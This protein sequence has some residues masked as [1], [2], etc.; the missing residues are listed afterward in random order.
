MRN[1]IAKGFVGFRLNHIHYYYTPK[2]EKTLLKENE[3]YHRL[4]VRRTIFQKWRRWVQEEQKPNRLNNLKAQRMMI[5][6]LTC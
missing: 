4:T 6:M 5:F 1:L 3:R 2:E